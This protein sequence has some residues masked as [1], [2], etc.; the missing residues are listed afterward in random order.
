[1]E[2]NTISV[3]SRAGIDRTPE[4]AQPERLVSFARPIYGRFQE[5]TT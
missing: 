1:M 2:G 5:K 3:M 4:T